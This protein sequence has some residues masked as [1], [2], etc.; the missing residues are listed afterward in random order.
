MVLGGP[1]A[2]GPVLLPTDGTELG[3]AWTKGGMNHI[4]M[5]LKEF[6]KGAAHSKKGI[7]SRS[8]GDYAAVFMTT[9]QIPADLWRNIA[10]Y[11]GAHVY[12]EE[13]DILLADRSVVA[14]HS[15][16]S[17][18]KTIKLPEKSRVRNLVTGKLVSRGTTEIKFKLEAPETCVFLLEH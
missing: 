4:G 2:Y 5:S 14:L 9:V 17:G 15:L 7:T 3:L 8:E 16:R 12:S 10:R 13:G 11:A 18:T 6:G 1:L